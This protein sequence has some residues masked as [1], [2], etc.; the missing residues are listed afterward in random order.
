MTTPINYRAYV[1]ELIN[2]MFSGQTEEG[3]V[4]GRRAKDIGKELNSLGGGDAL[5]KCMNM[6]VDN[7]SNEYS[8]EYLS[9]L[10]ELEFAFSGISNDFQI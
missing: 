9:Y 3:G 4:F 6:L 2:M 1:D 8:T 10:H 5:H 7:L